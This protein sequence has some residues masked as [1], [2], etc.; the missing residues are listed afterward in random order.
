MKGAAMKG[1]AM[2]S[3]SMERRQP[4]KLNLRRHTWSPMARTTA[5]HQPREDDVAIVVVAAVARGTPRAR[6]PLWSRW[7]RKVMR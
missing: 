2:K 3:T 6:R 5:M 4:M 1:A 7:K